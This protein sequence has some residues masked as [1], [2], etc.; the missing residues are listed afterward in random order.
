MRRKSL[1]LGLL[2]TVVFLWLAFRGVD[3]GELGGA[4]G[5]LTVRAG[6]IPPPRQH[7]PRQRAQPCAADADE[8]DFFT[9]TDPLRGAC[10]KVHSA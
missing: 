5:A 10:C 6:D 2:L 4:L 9:H 7:D 8:M 3:F 1:W